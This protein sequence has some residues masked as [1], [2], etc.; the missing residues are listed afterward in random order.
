M[1]RWWS[2]SQVD[3]VDLY[4]RQSLY[5]V[6]ALFVSV[7]VLALAPQGV[8]RPTA[9]TEVAIGGVV[10]N[11]VAAYVMRAMISLDPATDPVPRRLVVGFVGL[12]LVVEALVFTLPDDLRDGASMLVFVALVFGLGAL[13][14]SRV[15]A[16]LVV[17]L[18][19]TVWLPTQD[20]RL[21]VWG[22]VAGLF[23]I[24]TLRSSLWLLTVVTE[25]DRARGAQAALAVAEERLRFS[26]DVHDVLGRQLSTIAVQAELAASLA[27][28]GDPGAAD[29]MLEVRSTAHEALREA[30][31]LA[32]GYRETS[33]DQELGGARSL[34]RSAGI[35]LELDVADLPPAWHEAAG[36]VVRETVTNVLRHSRATTVRV[37]YD[38]QHLSVAND[39][40]LPASDA[41]GSGLTGLAER[42][43][44]LG[45]ALDVSRCD[46]AFTVTA[47]LPAQVTAGRSG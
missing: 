20:P 19:L 17:A 29:R 8:D 28:R 31:E 21:A 3:W 45:V 25:L 30:R 46:D 42:L 23:L 34:L 33:L 39:R 35:Q 5:V 1:S 16:V 6:H 12:L 44:P 27:R 14:D 15:S 36:W 38:G 41:V 18:V 9:A 7:V 10:V 13:R 4:T 40:P 26:H 47:T 32:R 11:L 2:R 24:F 43:E 22:L 37:A